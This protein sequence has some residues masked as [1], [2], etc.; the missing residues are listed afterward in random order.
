MSDKNQSANLN[1]HRPSAGRRQ[2]LSLL[3]A[4]ACGVLAATACGGG[5]GGNDAPAPGPAPVPSPPAGPV[6]TGPPRATT[7]N[8]TLSLPWGLAFLP[9][10]RM[11]VTE[12]AGTMVALSANGSSKVNVTGVPAVVSSGGGALSF[13][14]NQGGLLDVAIYPPEFATT[15]WVY[16]T[17]SEAGSGAGAGTAGL[18][19]GR[20]KL[21]GNALQ[22]FE[23]I[24]RQESK[25]VGPAHFG[26]RLA[27]GSDGK[28]FVTVGDRLQYIST[29]LLST[30]QALAPQLSTSTL[31]K[32]IR[33]E[34]DGSV[35]PGNPTSGSFTADRIWSSGHRNPQGAAIHPTTGELWVTEHGPLGG[36]ELNRVVKGGN[37]GWPVV[38][39]GC[40]YNTTPVTIAC[41]I[42]GGVHTGFAEPVSFFG[43]T[44]I[45]P[46]GLIFYT[47]SQFPE[48]Q[49]DAIFGAVATDSTE[50]GLWRIEL[51]GNAETDREFISISGIDGERVRTVKQGP[52]GWLYVLTNSGKLILV[53]RQ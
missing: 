47:G 36:D 17:Y 23:V 49:G 33:I 52:D 45:G 39:Y 22:D 15:P 5:G 18:A 48:W 41:R 53:D 30:T 35:P 28:L 9:D 8:S 16:I 3:L 12:K 40:P 1:D 38:S 42:G 14:N 27:F 26:S 11:L 2:S 7:L 21:V 50:K 31:G 43:P 44:S 25:N 51:S 34:R 19:V 13:Q 32:V 24:F 29:D 4:A 20:G 6:L 46:S 37:Y 10:G